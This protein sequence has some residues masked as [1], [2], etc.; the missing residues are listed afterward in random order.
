MLVSN[1]SAYKLA[2]TKI[3]SRWQHYSVQGQPVLMDNKLIKNMDY[4]T[5]PQSRGKEERWRD[6]MK[7][8]W[9]ER[10]KA[11]RKEGNI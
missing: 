9:K 11:E 3:T 6:R 1:I 7:E 2:F 5:L 4:F 8:E 10:R